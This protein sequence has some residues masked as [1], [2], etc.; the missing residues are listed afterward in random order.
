MDGKI[1]TIFRLKT[2]CLPWPMISHFIKGTLL[3]SAFMSL[4]VVQCCRLTMVLNQIV[5]LIMNLAQNQNLIFLFFNQNIH[6]LNVT[7]LLSA[8]NT[9]E[10]VHEIC[11]NVVCTT[12]K[13][14]DQPAHTPSLIRAFA[15]GLNIL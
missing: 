10:P 2:F 6:R 9:Y 7:V 8:V 11:N 4:R 12:S 5:S 3:M 13:A 15:S 14:S 1:F